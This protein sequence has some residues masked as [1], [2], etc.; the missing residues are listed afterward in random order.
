MF[1]TK[2]FSDKGQ[3]KIRCRS[4]LDETDPKHSYKEGLYIFLYQHRKTTG[5]FYLKQKLN[6]NKVLLSYTEGKR[7]A[8]KSV[9]E[10]VK[11]ISDESRNMYKYNK[12]VLDIERIIK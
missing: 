7:I 3:N 2:V 10:E 12:I 4:Q 6:L 5:K 11:L 1:V 8:E 9:S